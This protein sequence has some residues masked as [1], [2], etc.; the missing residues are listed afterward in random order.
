MVYE[1]ERRA[2]VRAEVFEAYGG[3]KCA[4][5]GETEPMFLTID[6]IANDGNTHRRELVKKIGKGGTAFFDWLRR[7][8]FPKGF[9][10][11]CRNCNWGKHANHG[12]CPHRN[13]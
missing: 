8:K 2:K 4:C 1:A 12:V 6:H 13:S 11:L 5:C 7:M 3:Y 9:Q 10:V